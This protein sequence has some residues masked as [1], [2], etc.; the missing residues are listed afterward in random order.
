M[1]ILM[2]TNTYLPHV[3]GV[4]RSVAAFKN[5]F[6]ERG[7]DVL[8][9][10]PEFSDQ[11]D[12]DDDVFRVPAIQEFN[13]S[14]FSVRLPVIPDLS[15]A[16]D[17]FKPDIVHS[18][19]P[20][21]LG[22]NALRVA[23][24]H[25]VPLVFTHHTMYER[26]T[27]YVPGDSD[28]MQ[29]FVIRLATGYCDLCD[30]VFA[31][32]Q[33]VK[34]IL[35]ERGATT[36]INVVPTGVDIDTYKRG[37]GS[38]LRQVLGIPEDA[39]VVGHL[40]RLALEKGLDVISE[41]VSAFLAKNED[42]H[43]LLAGGGPMLNEI[44]TACKTAGAKDRL[45]HCGVVSGD[46]LV[47]VYKAMDVFAFASQSET[48]GMVI[49]EAMAAGVPVV[50]FDASGVR[51]VLEDGVN[52]RMLDGSD[53]KTMIDA[54]EWF[55]GRSDEAKAEMR[56]NALATADANSISNCAD[57]ALS[58]YEQAIDKPTETAS[59]KESMWEQA[60]GRLKA[61]W[62]I[63]SNAADAARSAFTADD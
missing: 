39:F 33:S 43:F 14:D 52:G 58:H 12:E 17:A 4:A 47:S 57:L 22:D 29:R 2:F 31:P 23:R 5:A 1:R 60:M 16:V 35:I 28:T 51:D 26:Y 59:T 10:A 50:A 61:E 56:S 20:F 19:H 63:L 24:E 41:A 27:H 30:M 34:D 48:Q 15:D 21:L 37:S 42:A 8:I 49:T 36:T 40:G 7:H 6:Q 9:V 18:H 62:D 32:S 45:H 13:G 44:K 55:R 46:I 11:P 53:P 38:G 54:L 25:Q 3:G